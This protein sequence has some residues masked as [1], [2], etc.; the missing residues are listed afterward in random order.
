MEI[1]V[2]HSEHFD[3]RADGVNPSIIVLHYTEIEDVK[4][5][6][7]IFMGREVVGNA[8]RVSAHYVIDQDGSIIRYV[9]EDR[10]A[11][12]AGRSYWCG[13]R[14]VNSHS[15][16]IEL[17]H[18]GHG[19][20]ELHYK[21]VQITS[22]AELCADITARYDIKPWNIV[23]HSDIAPGRKID[24]GDFFPWEKLHEEYGIGHWPADLPS[25]EVYGADDTLSMLHEYGYDP[26]VSRDELIVAFKDHF[27]PY[28][29]DEAEL[30]RIAHALISSKKS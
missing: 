17:V 26:E 12:H 23:G 19:A 11:W 25:G 5:V 21:R 29:T 14:D 20:D 22:L 2:R 28:E 24:P 18:G 13:T 6:D 7:D 8:G 27:A 1:D 4:R 30:C 9:D 3:E 10:R 15:I 16:G